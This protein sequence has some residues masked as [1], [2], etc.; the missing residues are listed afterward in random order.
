[1]TV[2]ELKEKLN[3]TQ[4]SVGDDAAQ[5]MGGCVC[6][7]LSWV[8]AHGVQNGAWITVQTHI[9][10]IAVATLLELACIII[11]E[12]IAVEQPT[13]D[14]A[15]EEGIAILGSDKSA[16]ELAGLMYQ[17]GIVPTTRQ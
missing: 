5:I 1:M 3:L 4:L 14:K 2:A 12:G 13:L 11:P 16:Y 9:N 10:I 6:D 15:A 8:M 17:S 7:L